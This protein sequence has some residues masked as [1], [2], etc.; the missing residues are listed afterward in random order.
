MTNKR[1]LVDVINPEIRDF[2]V[3]MGAEDIYKCYQCGKCSSICPWFQVG[4]YD[5]PIFRLPLE[6]ALGMVASSE[7]K[8]ELEEEVDK[9]YRCV[10]CEACVDQC[11]HGINIPNILR[12]ARRLLVDFGSY[13]DILK[14]IV[15]KIHDVGNP[16]GEER[17]KRSDWAKQLNVPNFQPGIEYL[18]FACCIPSYDPRVQNVAQA[19][20][21]ILQKSGVSFGILGVQENCCGE[22]IRRIGAEKVFEEVTKSNISSF[23]SAG[24]KNILVTS[25][26][27]YTSFENDYPEFGANFEVFHITQYFSGLI[28]KGKIQPIKSFDKKVVY[29][30]PCNLGR[31]NGIYEEPRNILRNI[32]GLELLEV[33][34]F[35]R[36]LSV[37]CGAGSGALWMEW[38]KDERIG[39]IRINQL[40]DT[41]AEI[42]AVACPYCLQMFEET[43]KSMDLNIQV[44]DIAEILYESLG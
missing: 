39:D 32:P 29:H 25:P 26:H 14:S 35:N 10:G 15:Q 1:S 33:E 44:M 12:A 19:T 23:E 43:I 4:T 8:K 17:E 20:V 31:Q 27:C 37:C 34:N 42:I 21:R 7:D 36:S 6:T 30:D 38:E 22:A 5:F 11:P 13:P 28:E 9:I 16:L 40:V 41:G 3:E 18:Y 24:V 2:L